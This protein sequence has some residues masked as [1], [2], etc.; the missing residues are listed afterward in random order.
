MLPT[1]SVEM[2]CAC[3]IDDVGDLVEE[4][5]PF[6]GQDLQLRYHVYSDLE[7]TT[8]E[9]ITGMQFTWTLSEDADDDG[10]YP[11]SATLVK[12][13][14][15]GITL[16]TPYATVT[17]SAANTAALTAG[18]RYRMQL[19]RTDSGNTYPVTGVGSFIPQAAPPRS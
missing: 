19:W 12:T 2:T 3:P 17:L 13:V 10:A 1:R 11:A 7:M 18:T 9:T 4:I 6:V 16:A 8:D 14:G 15:S 5:T